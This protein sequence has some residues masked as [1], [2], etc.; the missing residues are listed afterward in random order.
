MA[1]QEIAERLRDQAA[2]Q[3]PWPEID[4]ISWVEA[5]GWRRVRRASARGLCL[6]EDESASQHRRAQGGQD[7]ASEFHPAGLRGGVSGIYGMT[8]PSLSLA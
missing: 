8:R 1:E 3:T 7:H 4:V 6:G 2:G 5:S